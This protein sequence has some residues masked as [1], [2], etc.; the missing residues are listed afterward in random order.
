MC[1]RKGIMST[2]AWSLLTDREFLLKMNHPCPIEHILEP[3]EIQW[4]KQI[5]EK[6]LVKTDKYYIYWDPDYMNKLKYIDLIG[7]SQE[8]EL[9]EV[10]SGGLFL[11]KLS[12]NKKLYTK[13]KQLGY[14]PKKFKLHFLMFEW[15]NKLFKLTHKL[16]LEFET[17][18]NQIKGKTLIC[19]QIRI[20]RKKAS[21]GLVDD[22]FTSRNETVKFWSLIK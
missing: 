16:K 6:K 18:L 3:N 1:P 12:E 5:E 10:R 22:F 2:Y 9:I 20:G 17:Y 14:E 15:Y 8:A 21:S 19:A 7:L 4:N 13:I 11:N